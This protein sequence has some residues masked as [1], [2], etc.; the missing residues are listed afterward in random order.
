MVKKKITQKVKKQPKKIVKKHNRLLLA[1]SI[2][3]LVVVLFVVRVIG[4]KTYTM[5]KLLSS[6][7]KSRIRLIPTPI[8]HHVI[9]PVRLPILMYHYIEYVTDKNDTI[10]K[11]LAILPS[12]FDAQIKTLQDAGYTFL[13]A[14]QIP[15]ILSGKV[16]LPEKPIILTFDDGYRD[17]YTDAYPILKKYNVPATAYIVP[18]FLDHPN[19]M[20]TS[21]LEEINKDGLVELAAHTVHH[22]YLKG[23]S[24]EHAKWEIEESK[25]ELEEQL[26]KPVVSFAYPYGAFDLEIAQLVQEAG[27][28]N[29]VS[30]LPGVELDG[31][32]TYF[33]FRIR[34]GARTGE[35]L[36]TY[37]KQSA[38][39][40][41]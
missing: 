35:E 6:S 33:I 12:T 1:G 38:F 34:P 5:M 19:Y 18:G 28:T 16:E 25:K 31:K 3:I 2:C 27:F 41:Y 36:L 26:K 14:S 13:T 10:R 37:L 15:D 40:P 7:E 11:S 30:T 23:A 9:L 29:A 17:F 32:N 24:K 8:L 22:A 4:N 21:Q 39:R 20:F